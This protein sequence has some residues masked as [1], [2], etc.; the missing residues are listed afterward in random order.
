MT[1]E[2]PRTYLQAKT[3]EN[4]FLFG[5]PLGRVNSRQER[6]SLMVFDSWRATVMK[7][8]LRLT[9]FFAKLDQHI[10]LIGRNLGWRCDVFHSRHWQAFLARNE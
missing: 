1:G 5:D 8:L 4:T 2:R 10:L 7:W 9:V 6:K 3:S